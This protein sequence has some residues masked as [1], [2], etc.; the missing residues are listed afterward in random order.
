[1]LDDDYLLVL[2]LDRLPQNQNNNHEIDYNYSSSNRITLI[3]RYFF[4]VM[5]HNDDYAY[6]DHSNTVWQRLT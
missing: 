2:D 5:R 1:M 4:I 3:C 6:L